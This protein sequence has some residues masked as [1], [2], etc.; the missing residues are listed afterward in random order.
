MTTL[1]N[2][3]NM[4]RARVRAV[5]DKKN[6]ENGH[7]KHLGASLIGRECERQLF[8]V[9]RWAQK[10]HFDGRVLR[11]FRRGQEEEQ[12]FTDD[13]RAI[14]CDVRDT[15]PD[16]NQWRFEHWGGHFGG[17]CDGIISSGVPEA[18]K[19][20]H[21]AEYKTHGN[22]SFQD[23]EK[24][25]VE[26]SKPEHVAQMQTYMGLSGMVWSSQYQIKRALYCAVNKD[27]DELHF[28]RIKFDKEVFTDILNKAHRI[29]FTDK[30]PDRITD[31]PQYY[32]C[33]WCDFYEI[34]HKR[35]FPEVN[36]RTCAHSTP[37]EDGTWHCD[38]MDMPLDYDTIPEGCG[39]HLF[40]PSL[41]DG[42][43]TVIDANPEENW[44]SYEDNKTNIN[45]INGIGH[46]T[47]IW[48]H[49]ETS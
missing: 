14:G 3:E 22:K 12:W 6:E 15:T 36:C 39:N 16:G 31:N 35:K 18:P 21:I 8:Y 45:F 10:P 49:S 29:I 7:R 9:F 37:K 41:I 46:K 38:Y 2:I 34:C 44:I 5:W 42:F 17:D 28:E 40:L 25:G 20:P 32:A 1:P 30:A 26:K 48:L 47:S 19:S 4:T 13:L 11:L 23:L 43:A 24:N 27:N 33:K